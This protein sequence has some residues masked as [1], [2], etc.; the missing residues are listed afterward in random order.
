MSGQL[1]TPVVLIGFNRPEVTARNL[2][3]IR[4]V[5]PVHLLLVADGPRAARPEDQ[6]KVAAVREAMRT[7][8]WPCRVE[9]RFSEENLGCEGNVETGLD[10]VFSTVE[11]AIVLE[12]DCIADPTFFRYAEELLDRYAEDSRV[13]HIAGNRHGVPSHLFGADSYRFSTW[14]SVWAWATWA[15]RWQQ[16]RRH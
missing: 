4:T 7:V 3:A 10:W 9:E 12:D 11:R 13:W 1:R 2:A 14:A 15:D 6:P 5:S 8:D 16:H